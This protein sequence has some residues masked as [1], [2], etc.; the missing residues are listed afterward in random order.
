[1]KRAIIA[2]L[3]LVLCSQSCFAEDTQ[4]P[5]TPSLTQSYQT[6][7]M[8]GAALSSVPIVVPPGRK[9]IQP[10]ISL[11]YSS[12]N[13]NGICGVGWRLE[14]G[15]IQRNTKRGVPE[16]DS[17]DTFVANVNGANVE[18][19][20]IGS[21]EYRARQEGAFLKFSYDG[22]YWQVKDKS[23]MSY[24]FGSS[25]NARQANSSGTFKW[26][27]DKVV[28]LHGNYMN[29]NYLHDQG[30]VYLQDVQYTGKEGGETPTNTAE[31][32]YET[33]N[34]LFSS[35]RSGFKVIT[36]KR[37]SAIDLKVSGQRARK[38]VINYSASPETQRSLLTSVTEYGSD[39]ATSLPPIRFEYQQGSTIGQ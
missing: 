6:D 21:G 4:A 17:T 19:V 32:I 9:G 34:D 30:Q 27:L 2:I 18:L 14:F 29:I 36:A 1:M 25:A 20:D 24:F 15:S 8:T 35:Y 26:Y 31:F 28:D 10:N 5:L 12:N 11:A 3:F 16:Y 37:L 13:P 39:G 7:L 33:R 23:G 22:A 38:Y